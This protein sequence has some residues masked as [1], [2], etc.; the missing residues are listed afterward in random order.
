MN[1]ENED[2]IEIDSLNSFDNQSIY[3]FDNIHINN[4]YN[5]S[6]NGVDKNDSI[7][8]IEKNKLINGVDKNDSINGFDNH[9]I[10]GVDNKNDSINGVIKGQTINGI[11]KN[12]SI[13]C[14]DNKND[15][16]NGI[17]KNYLIND[18]K[19]IND[20]DSLYDIDINNVDKKYVIIDHELEEINNNNYSL[21]SKKSGLRGHIQEKLVKFY[22]QQR[23]LEHKLY[24]IKYNNT[25]IILLLLLFSSILTLIEASK[26]L[27][28]LNTYGTSLL[29]S[30]IITF[31]SSYSKVM[32][33]QELLEEL[34][35]SLEKCLI[36][37]TELKKVQENLI[38]CNNDKTF[39]EI[40]LNFLN[41]V[42]VGYLNCQME[43]F[44]AVPKNQQKNIIKEIYDV[45]IKIKE[46]YKNK[47]FKLKKIEK[48]IEQNKMFIK[49]V[50]DEELGI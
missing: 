38:F 17:E 2:E 19:V 3:D 4:I 16:I 21:L 26:E 35:K 31:L 1:N 30:L 11:E 40:K 43:I 42:Y 48:E 29:L 44:K 45:D 12:H 27:Y 22:E 34:V 15:L 25:F 14:V 20:N 9:S 47:I 33:H 18:I 24:Q 32:K 13:N 10:N 6:I 37:Q 39:E 5:Q 41:N 8:D 23:L 49:N 50:K 7:N 28:K 36:T 46:N